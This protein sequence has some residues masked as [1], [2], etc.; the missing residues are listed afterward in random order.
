MIT[1]FIIEPLFPVVFWR[2][3][4]LGAKFCSMLFLV[5]YLK[6]FFVLRRCFDISLLLA[7]RSS[8]MDVNLRQELCPAL[9][10]S[11]I[12]VA[13]NLIKSNPNIHIYFATRTFLE[14]WIILFSADINTWVRKYKT[15][16]WCVSAA[17]C[18]WWE[19]TVRIFCNKRTP[20]YKRFPDGRT[21]PVGNKSKME[22]IAAFSY[23]TRDPI[24]CASSDQRN[25]H[26]RKSEE[27]IHVK[28]MNSVTQ[29]QN[30]IS[31]Q[32]LFTLDN[33]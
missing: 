21:L 12:R 33:C 18:C 29:F 4:R 15:M 2:K 17:E 8:L 28:S 23:H 31:T 9:N 3:F 25:I 32:T 13:W 14:Q 20:L 16:L 6:F 27:R 19:K 22:N 10:F 24:S 11:D 7:I 1:P 5:F 26:W 30:P